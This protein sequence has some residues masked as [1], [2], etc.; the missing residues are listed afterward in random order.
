MH[1]EKTVLVP[2]DFHCVIEYV[3]QS[4]PAEG[5]WKSHANLLPWFGGLQNWKIAGT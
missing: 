3:F 5:R 1:R 4:T 2:G